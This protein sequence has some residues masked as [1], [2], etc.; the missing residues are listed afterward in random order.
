MFGLSD[1]VIRRKFWKPEGPRREC[2]YDFQGRMLGHL[3][4]WREKAVGLESI[5]VLKLSYRMVSRD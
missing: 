5:K 4:R 1:F 2:E 3:G